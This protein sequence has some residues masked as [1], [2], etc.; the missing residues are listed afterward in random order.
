M[1]THQEHAK[2]TYQRYSTVMLVCNVN[3]LRYEHK[4]T[5]PGGVFSIVSRPRANIY[6]TSA[7]GTR[8]AFFAHYVDKTFVTVTSI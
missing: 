5:S 4:I 3:K 2:I 6:T 1:S 7:Y 8:V